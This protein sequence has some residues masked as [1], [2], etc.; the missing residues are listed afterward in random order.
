MSTMLPR[1]LNAEGCFGLAL[2]SAKSPW[3]SDGEAAAPA[4]LDLRL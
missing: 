2:A 3:R 1:F 4:V